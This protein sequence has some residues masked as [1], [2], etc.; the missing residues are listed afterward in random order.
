MTA[1]RFIEALGFGGLF[2]L[3]AYGVQLLIL[4]ATVAA[5]VFSLAMMVMAGRA[6][7]AAKRASADAEAC[8][9]SAQDMVVEAR[10]LAARDRQATERVHAAEAPSQA[11]GKRS[12]PIRVSARET[13]TEAEVEILRLKDAD[14]AAGNRALNE[15]AESASVPK[16]LLTGF[17]NRRR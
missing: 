3:D 7:G 1:E 15:A 14:R 12:A 9:R 16:G 5:L 17:R 8:L 2:A 11:N 4:A 6:A 10:Q 13:T